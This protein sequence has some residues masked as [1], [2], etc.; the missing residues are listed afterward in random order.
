MRK[1]NVNV[2]TISENN[3][4]VIAE[5]EENA[6]EKIDKII[7]NNEENENNNYI[8]EVTSVDEEIENICCQS[9]EYFC[10]ECGSCLYKSE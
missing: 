5:N 4:E 1:F 2:K 7:S 8:F 6:I 3:Y 10:S 9:C